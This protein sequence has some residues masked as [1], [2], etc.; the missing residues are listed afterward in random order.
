MNDLVR[1]VI[2]VN[3]QL[4]HTQ[5]NLNQEVQLHIH[6]VDIN[7]ITV[8]VSDIL[9]SIRGGLVSVRQSKLPFVDGLSDLV[10]SIRD[11]S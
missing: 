5:I 6:N 9:P 4:H 11:S 7:S 8:S 2:R 1:Q 3:H 10:A